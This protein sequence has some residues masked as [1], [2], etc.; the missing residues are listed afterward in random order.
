MKRK[1][2]V[3]RHTVSEAGVLQDVLGTVLRG[4]RGTRIQQLLKHKA[5]TVNGDVVS[6]GTH[7]LKAGD[8]V[9]V[10]FNRHRSRPHALPEGLKLIFEDADL[11]VVDKP[12]GLLTIATE[13][14][15]RRTAYALLT[16]YAHGSGAGRVFIVHRLDRDTSGLLVFARSEAIK[17]TLQ[18]QWR[19]VE[20]KY[21]AVVEGTPKESAGTIRS[22]L[23]ENR[24]MNVYE[25]SSEEGAL[26]VTHYRVLQSSTRYALLEIVLET[27]RKNQIR[28]HL[29][30]LGH[31]VVGDRKYGAH[32][33]PVGRLAL[34]ASTLSFVHPTRGERL[35]FSS[36]LP[37]ALKKL[38]EG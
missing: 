33:N 18:D 32:G 25:T 2:N 28:V 38:M 30:E 24:A 35:R 8:V 5:V 7:A 22:R 20:K 26:A 9:A 21:L 34:H 37:P 31:A 1:M 19:T 36:P 3:R 13:H 4:A 11:I 10:H 29:A 6:R 23:R 15:R 16:A 17:R 14:E 12:P 27:G